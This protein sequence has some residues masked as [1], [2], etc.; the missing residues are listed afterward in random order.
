MTESPEN[1]TGASPSKEPLPKLKS[2]V[3]IAVTYLA[4]FYLFGGSL[5]L[6]YIDHTGTLESSTKD[7]FLYTA[8][9][10]TGILTYWFGTRT[11]Q[12]GK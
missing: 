8:P 2:S 1:A 3:R 4:A 12:K 5:A 11:A 6:V 9:V 10:A 7:L